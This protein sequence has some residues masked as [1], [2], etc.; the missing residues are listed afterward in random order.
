[1]LGWLHD[2]RE[3]HEIRLAR[4]PLIRELFQGW[5]PDDYLC[6]ERDGRVLKNVEQHVLKRSIRTIVDHRTGRLCQPWFRTE[7]VCVG[8][9]EPDQPRPALVAYPIHG[10]DPIIVW[11]P[12]MS[13]VQAK[14]YRS[15]IIDG[16]QY[17]V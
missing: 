16:V 11:G 1:M 3:S 9:I 17:K 8:P 15:V 12:P 7:L 4:I 5:H 14:F 13:G 2:L 6:D 10:V